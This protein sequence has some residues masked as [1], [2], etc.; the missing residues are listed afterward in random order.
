MLTSCV[1]SVCEKPILKIEGTPV[2]AMAYTTYFEERSRY[3]D[4]IE[5]G[6]R[7]FFVNASFTSLPIN[8]A[9]TGF[10]PFRAGIYE[11]EEHPD[12]SEFE[13][14][15]RKI[16]KKCPDAVIFPRVY[17]SMPKRWVKDHPEET[18]PTL[19]GGDRE[20][21]FSEKFR[22]DG[23]ALL[24]R[25]VRHVKAS[26]YASRVGGWQLCGG[27]TQEW[28]HH[29]LNGCL[30]PNA[31]KYYRRWVKEK[32]GADGAV[33]PSTEVFESKNGSVLQ[34]DENAKRYVRFSEESVAENIDFFAKT[35]KEEADFSQVVGLFYGY[36]FEHNKSVLFGSHGLGRLISSPY[37]DFFSSPNAYTQNRAFGI[38][39]ADMIPVDSVK[40]HGKMAFIECDIRTYLTMGV[41]ESRPGVYPLDIYPVGKSSVWSGP[42]TP[43][44]SR[45]AL[46]KCFAHQI[47]KAS[48]IWWFDMWGGWYADLLL[49][50]ELKRML[51][52][53]EEE[54]NRFED[55]L[56]A[57]AVFFADEKG[58]ENLLSNSSALSTHFEKGRGI[59]GSR[60]SMGLT[61]APYDSCMTED[62]EALLDRYKAAVFPFPVPSEAGERAIAL[63]RERKIPYLA[64][65]PD[66]DTLTP[67]EIRAFLKENRV[68]LYTENRDVVYAGQGYLALH[69]T[70]A[71]EKTLALPRPM[72]VVPVF[73]ANLSAQTTDRITFFLAE[74][75]TALFR[76]ENA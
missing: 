11:D 12:Y 34:N 61:G 66:H 10:T 72:R 37:V 28:F 67:E 40:H 6:Y 32:Y 15:V 44:G 59:I 57:E 18:V 41:Q 58:Y 49:M 65:T 2:A 17:V 35:V 73:G 13:D 9:K 39:W 43:E 23:A 3:E 29:N 14:A 26:D 7:I 1:E 16:L 69:S 60:T 24:R 27:Q 46:R 53:Y 55:P 51:I 63:C 62:A 22:E 47:T 54:P 38:D 64:A 42:P 71:G 68:H 20:M 25:F 5:A 33:L 52:I 21:L 76:V 74:N 70:V 36:T 45:E 8:S 75:A 56:K 48:A 30:C 19:K 50:D 4:F 31:E